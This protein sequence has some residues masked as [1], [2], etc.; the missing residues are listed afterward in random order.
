[1]P[2]GS[3]APKAVRVW[4]VPDDE[5]EH[6][7]QPR[8]DVLAPQVVAGDDRL[9]VPVGAQVRAGG[10]ELLAQLDVV[11]DL[12]VEQDP[13]AA[14]VV[15]EGLRAA[16]DVDDRQPVERQDGAAVRPHRGVVGPAV[17]QA[18]QRLRGR[19]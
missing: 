13:V 10:G 7:A 19:R 9:G 2:K 14:P 3:R 5:G 1:M 4:R 11:V 16:L 6:A 17:V 8:H 15:G 12:A 18:V